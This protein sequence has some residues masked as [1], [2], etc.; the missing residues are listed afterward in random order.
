MRRGPSLRER[1]H[2]KLKIENLQSI[3]FPPVLLFNPACEFRFIICDLAI[4]HRG[5]SCVRVSRVSRHSSSF[6]AERRADQCH[7]WLY[8]NAGEDALD[9]DPE[10]FGGGVG[11]RTGGGTDRHLGRIQSPARADARGAGTANRAT[12][13]V[14]AGCWHRFLLP[15][16]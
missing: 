10:P 2:C 16:W 1:V 8:K 5:R 14:F 7:L 3:A 15:R 4:A 9:F 11:R 6:L 13:A 12:P